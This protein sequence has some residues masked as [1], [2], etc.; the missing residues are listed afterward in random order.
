MIKLSGVSKIFGKVKALDDVNITIDNGDIYG[1]IGPNGAGKST[2]LRLLA[3]LLAPTSGTV[4]INGLDVTKERREVMKLVG[5]MPDVYGLYEDMTV[6]EYLRFYCKANFIP[7]SKI[8]R[9]VDDVL[10]LTDL[11]VKRDSMIQGL[12][13]G[14]RQRVCLSRAL[15][16]DPKILL[17]D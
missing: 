11:T 7:K 8:R 4:A 6:L 13:R 3:G 5:Y 12:S 10:E 14:M 17:L 2:T 16:H 15:L 1:F 9:I